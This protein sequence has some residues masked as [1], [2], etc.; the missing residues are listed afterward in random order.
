[1]INGNFWDFFSGK[2]DMDYCPRGCPMCD[3]D[4][5]MDAGIEFRKL[6]RVAFAVEAA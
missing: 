5:E 2:E 3:A 4:A 1:M 6:M